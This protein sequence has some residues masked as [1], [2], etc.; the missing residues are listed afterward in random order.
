MIA[1]DEYDEDGEAL[2]A[3][4]EALSDVLQDVLAL[5][6]AQGETPL[7]WRLTPDTVAAIYDG[8]PEDM[9]LLFDIPVIVAE[10]VSTVWELLTRLGAVTYYRY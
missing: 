10:D 4:G 2:D 6:L 3:A 9:K 7:R 8:D 5:A 1:N